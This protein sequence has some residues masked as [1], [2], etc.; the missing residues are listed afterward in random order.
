MTDR[1]PWPSH[2]TRP[3]RDEVEPGIPATSE[4]PRDIPPGSEDEEEAAPLDFPQGVEEWGTTPREELVGEPF[5]LRVRREEPHVQ[6]A[7]AAEAGGLSLYEPGTDED[8]EERE[9]LDDE[10]DSVG[11]L[12]SEDDVTIGPEEQAMHIEDEPAGLNYD[13]T[14][15]YLDGTEGAEEA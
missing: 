6:T 5:E 1:D 11:E 8:I 14:P 15:G 3:A 12:N 13:P 2:S 9:G 10:P 7:N 4:M